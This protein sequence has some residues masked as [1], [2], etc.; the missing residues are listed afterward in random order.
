MTSSVELG[1]P[2]EPKEICYGYAGD[3]HR[4]PFSREAMT[5]FVAHTLPPESH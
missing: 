3:R 5:P 1:I 4:L 2:L